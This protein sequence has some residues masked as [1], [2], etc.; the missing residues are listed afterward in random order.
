MARHEHTPEMFDSIAA[1][2]SE[3]SESIKSIAD[4]MRSEHLA[5]ALIHG[6]LVQ[7]V[8]LPAIMEW[9]HKATGDVKAQLR[10]HK[11]GVPSKAELHKQATENQKLTAAGKKLAAA[12]K[13][14]PK[15]AAKK[16][17]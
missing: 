9:M 11:I 13:P 1:E 3:A 7:N 8:H 14:W 17:L 6:T 12:K 2:L 15:K 4:M 5:Y 10:S 16:K